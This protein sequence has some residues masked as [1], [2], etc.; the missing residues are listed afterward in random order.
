MLP[1]LLMFRTMKL[2]RFRPIALVA[3][4]ILVTP[5][6]A[7]GARPAQ[8]A[9]DPTQNDARIGELR[10]EI[11]EAGAAETAALGELEAVQARRGEAQARV[12]AVQQRLDEA[13]FAV[14]AAQA[15]YDEVAARFFALEAKINDT[16]EQLADAKSRFGDAVVDLYQ[17]G[18]SA[19]VVTLVEG[20]D[21]VRDLAAGT[22]YLE[23]VSGDRRDTVDD[24]TDKRNDLEVLSADLEAQRDEALALEETLDQRR[25]ELDAVRSDQ[26]AALD[27][28]AAEEATEADVV[29]GIQ[30]RKGEFEAELADLEAESQAITQLI[31]AM[32]QPEPVPTASAP[33]GTG[34]GGTGGGGTGGGGGSV[35]SGQFLRPVPGPITSYF[36]NRV[37]PIY[38]TVRFHAGIDFGAAYGTPIAAAGTGVVIAA[39]WQGGYGNA[40][41][42]DHGGGIATLYGHQSSLAVSTG[43]TVTAG[44][45]VGYVGSTGAS[46]GAHLHWEVRVNGSP[47]DPLGYL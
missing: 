10:S 45:T 19:D 13:T 1:V 25:A 3:A 8:T 27:A 37:H 32:Q 16:E 34:G 12:A 14:Q 46:T 18:G 38:G 11:G 9:L 26:Q 2:M 42:I 47:V 30:A 28:A 41:V 29:A 23:Q 31:L 15:A 43:Q 39:G 20:A 5:V 24:Y 40:V 22:R 33:S 7:A 36:G 44:Q 6:A 21:S 35:G 17:G 4:A